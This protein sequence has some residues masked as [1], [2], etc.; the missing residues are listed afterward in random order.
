MSNSANSAR[1]RRKSETA[2]GLTRVARRLTIE[3]G[4]S[5]FTIEE[6][7]EE[8]G[9][10]RRTFFNYYSS[11]ESA[12]FGIP[13]DLDESR[14]AERFLASGPCGAGALIDDLIA[15]VLER[16]EVGGLTAEDMDML[17]HVFERE[18]RLV[19]R[20]L[21]LAGEE[22]RNDIKLV[23]RRENWAA[24]DRRA[25]AAVQLVGALFHSSIE[26]VFRPE[27]DQDLTSLMR[28]GLSAVRELFP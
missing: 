13:I 11:K 17:T 23:E 4:L 9:V 18:P 26:E 24:G 27:T 14:A 5:G 20:L 28:N 16:W 19:G 25:A 2:R 7:C 15:L 3:C 21:E 12:V 22:A 6:V 10:S 1:G 8:V